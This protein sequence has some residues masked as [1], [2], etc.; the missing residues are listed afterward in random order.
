MIKIKSNDAA[1]RAYAAKERIENALIAA[2]DAGRMAD[3]HR[4]AAA[5][6]RLGWM[7]SPERIATIRAMIANHD[8]RKGKRRNKV[9]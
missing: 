6:E 9:A 2:L 4:E 8:R 3:A 5:L 7:P 1:V